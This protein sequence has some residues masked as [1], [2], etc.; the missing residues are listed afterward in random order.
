MCRFGFVFDGFVFEFAEWDVLCVEIGLNF[1][2]F[3][4]LSKCEFGSMGQ[5]FYTIYGDFSPK[6][7]SI[8]ITLSW[9]VCLIRSTTPFYMGVYGTVFWCRIPFLDRY[10]LK[11]REVYSPPLSDHSVFTLC[12]VQFST[13][14]NHREK[15]VSASSFDL[16]E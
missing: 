1:V 16:S 14:T 12:P 13:L 4:F 15:T 6:S 9:I 7:W 2:F 11:A 3:G 10:C 8:A 5:A